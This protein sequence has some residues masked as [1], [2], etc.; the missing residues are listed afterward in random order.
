MG[1]MD[2]FNGMRNGPGT[3]PRTGSGMSPIAMAVLGLLAYKAM[4]GS[5]SGSSS[6]ATAQG[7]T[8]GSLLDDLFPR[9]AGGGSATGGL[10]GLVSGGLGDLLKQFQSAGKGDVAQSWIGPGE[11]KPVSPQDLGAV[12]TPQQIDFLT[13]RTGL[14][15]DELLSALS[16]HLP[17]AVDRLTPAGRVPTPNEMAQMA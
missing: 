4:K 9:S 5:A 13:A 11:N 2:I 1:L 16:Q 10:G 17:E 6:N 8:G 12:L 3:A 15:R 7:R 14:S